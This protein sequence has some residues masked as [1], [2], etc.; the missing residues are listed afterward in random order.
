MIELDQETEKVI[1]NAILEGKQAGEEGSQLEGA[2]MGVI[3]GSIV[4][5]GQ[6]QRSSD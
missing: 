5:F 6:V 2:N 1:E 4:G 3:N